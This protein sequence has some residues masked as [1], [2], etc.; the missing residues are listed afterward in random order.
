MSDTVSGIE[1]SPFMHPLVLRGDLQNTPTQRDQARLYLA[2][3]GA[4]DLA[5]VLGL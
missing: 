2:R 3:K 5:G 4:L 1:R